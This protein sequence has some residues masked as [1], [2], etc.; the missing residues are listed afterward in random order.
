[1]EGTVGNPVVLD[2]SPDQGPKVIYVTQGQIWR[3]LSTHRREKG[4]LVEIIMVMGDRV[5]LETLK[6][7]DGEDPHRATFSS[8]ARR[9]FDGKAA[10][11][12]YVGERSQYESLYL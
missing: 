3:D 7:S 2:V 9:R 10:G 5:Y 6:N 12:E 11:F 4:R 8:T 1:M